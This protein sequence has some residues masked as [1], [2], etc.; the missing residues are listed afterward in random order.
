MMSA[1]ALAIPRPIVPMFGTTGTFTETRRSGFTVFSSSISSA[2]SSIEY[3][4]WLFEG[5]IRSVPGDALRA[6]ATFSETLRPGRC[7]PSPGFAPWP[8]LIS[9]T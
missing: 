5:E 4:S 9:A 7:P 1:P 2:R 3:R 6:S 8:I